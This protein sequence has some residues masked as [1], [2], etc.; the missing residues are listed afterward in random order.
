MM[1]MLFTGLIFIN[2]LLCQ[3]G[4]VSLQGPEGGAMTYIICLPPSYIDLIGTTATM[5][6]NYSGGA[7][8]Y[9]S[10]SFGARWQLREKGIDPTRGG[11]HQIDYDYNN[12]SNIYI[13]QGGSAN[14]YRGGVYKTT[15]GGLTW[16]DISPV[17]TCFHAIHCSRKNPNILLA[18]ASYR[19]IY[20]ST[21]AG[22][23]WTKINDVRCQEFACDPRCPDTIYVAGKVT[24]Y[25]Y[26][27]TDGGLTWTQIG[28][29]LPFANIY[30]I[31]VD[32]QNSNI[33]YAISDQGVSQSG[34]G[35]YR[36]SDFGNTWSLRIQAPSFSHFYK[37]RV[38]PLDPN[39]VWVVGF[40][41]QG[42]GVYL[43]TNRGVSF[44]PVSNFGGPSGYGVLPLP[45]NS[46]GAIVSGYGGFQLTTD[47]GNTWQGRNYRLH[48]NGGSIEAVSQNIIYSATY[49]AR[50]W[51]TIQ[52]TTDGGKRW[53][54]ILEG[55]ESP[56]VAV[57]PTDVN[58][59]I[60]CNG[61]AVKSTN[62]GS[63]WYPYE[64]TLNRVVFS[65]ANA[66]YVWGAK[67]Q[68]QAG[69]PK[70][71]YKSANK[72]D[73]YTRTSTDT[74]LTWVTVAPHP[75][76]TNIVLAIANFNNYAYIFRTTDCGRNWTAVYT[77]PYFLYLYDIKFSFS[78]PNI[79]YACGY[80]LIVKS[81]DGGLTW[82]QL[83]N[84]N[85]DMNNRLAIN[86]AN[87]S[88]VLIANYAG[89]F[90]TSDG[91]NSWSDIS[92]NLTNAY[93]VAWLQVGNNN[94]RYASND[95][96]IHTL[97]TLDTISPSVTVIQ[98]NGGEVLRS[99]QSYNIL[100]NAS[101]NLG[102]D[103]IDIFYSIN[104]GA[105]YNGVA[106]NEINDGSYSWTVP[107]TPS[108]R[109]YVR[110]D[111]YDFA[112]NSASDRSN[113]YFTIE[114]L[115]VEEKMLEEINDVTFEVRGFGQPRI[116]CTVNTMTKLKLSV[117]NT[118]GQCLLR[119]SSEK[120]VGQKSWELNHLPGGVYF[121]V[122]TV[123]GDKV[124]IKKAVVVK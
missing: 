101:D 64:P 32:P 82:S 47:L 105:S 93:D 59:V 114:D 69:Y 10:R 29:N 53:V 13:A 17:D 86:P 81:T 4:W 7:G 102:V 66:N 79:V 18:G 113:N 26:R 120:F 48:A 21:N 1:R 112:G 11:I 77:G 5:E 31:A 110:I 33:L 37:V 54:K 85:L 83:P 27:S 19:G 52:K 60:A 97:G 42:K 40:I 74:F 122:L 46:N 118:L 87:P 28:T 63:S 38:S 115:A 20:R 50:Y 43:S 91:G 104:G 55:T 75:R 88:Q 71:I 90:Y 14:G 116:Y 34:V 41:Y 8:L 36:S 106:Y 94:Y 73:S 2:L 92:Y 96:G 9:Y 89:I 98:P 3:Q 68:S 24:D 49:G 15:N 124:K 84:P 117:Y 22:V 76:D 39:I 107:R 16:Q 30:S 65:R 95:R 123:N 44:Q 78:S 57:D 119:Y 23:T 109:C 80:Q 62:G 12:P 99:G 121:V 108:N 45:S 25:I 56:G 35:L 58:T 67:N 6:V 72:G 103:D 111:A 51:G 100:W 70:G 61:M